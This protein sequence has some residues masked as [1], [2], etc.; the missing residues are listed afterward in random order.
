[1]VVR[2]PEKKDNVCQ[3]AMKAVG[4]F[5]LGSLSKIGHLERLRSNEYVIKPVKEQKAFGKGVTDDK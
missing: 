4:V 1:M 3:R 5:S 2:N